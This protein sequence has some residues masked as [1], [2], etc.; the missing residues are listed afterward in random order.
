MIARTEPFSEYRLP[1]VFMTDKVT[2]SQTDLMR[3][4]N[5]NRTIRLDLLLIGGQ[6]ATRSLPLLLLLRQ[7]LLLEV[8]PEPERRLR[9]QYPHEH[10]EEERRLRLLRRIQHLDCP[11]ASARLLKT[12]LSPQPVYAH[13][14]VLFISCKLYIVS[15]CRSR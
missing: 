13:I 9:A 15:L 1:K 3:L 2:A 6:H 11:S 4:G 12:A 14:N 5:C 10:Q 8:L 7:G